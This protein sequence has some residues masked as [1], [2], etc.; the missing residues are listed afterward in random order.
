MTILK[1]GSM[2]TYMYYIKEHIH[3]LYMYNMKGKGG[4]YISM[5]NRIT[6][7][8]GI[9]SKIEKIPRDKITTSSG[10]LMYINRNKTKLLSI[11]C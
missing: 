9:E 5:Q 4:H 10:L 3:V 7:I 6:P 11:I 8:K 1:L 2:F